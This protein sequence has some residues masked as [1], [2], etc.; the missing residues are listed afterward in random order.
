LAHPVHAKSRKA[1]IITFTVKAVA[2]TEPRP[3]HKRFFT[4]FGFSK[5]ILWKHESFV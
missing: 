3:Q 2:R 4:H 1:Y 5:R